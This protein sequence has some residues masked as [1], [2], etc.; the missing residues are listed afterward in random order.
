[1]ELLQP[2]LHFLSQAADWLRNLVPFLG[3]LVQVLAPLFVAARALMWLGRWTRRVVNVRRRRWPLQLTVQ[4]HSAE[5][6]SEPQPHARLQVTFTALPVAAPVEVRSAGLVYTMSPPGPADKGQAAARPQGSGSIVGKVFVSKVQSG[7]FTETF[8]LPLTGG[9]MDV[10]INAT[11][12]VN[13]MAKAC[14]ASIP[15]VK[16][17]KPRREETSRGSADERDGDRATAD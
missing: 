10:A 7:P 16:L 5:W 11:L 13:A 12:L 6:V 4:R 9:A 17:T 3:P 8:E 15:M 2:L 14:T 1:M